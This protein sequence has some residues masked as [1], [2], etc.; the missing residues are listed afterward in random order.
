VL[1]VYV[2]NNDLHEQQRAYKVVPNYEA[3]VSVNPSVFVL[4]PGDQMKVSVVIATASLSCGRSGAHAAKYPIRLTVTDSSD[5]ITDVF[6]IDL[7][8]D[9]N[10]AQIESRN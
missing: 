6:A 5:K 7:T 1:S 10:A 9:P 8:I 4:G 2:R 3:F